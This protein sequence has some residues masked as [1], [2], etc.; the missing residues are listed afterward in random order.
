MKWL[1]ALIIV[2]LAL[3]TWLVLGRYLVERRHRGELVF[4]RL[5]FPRGLEAGTVESFLDGL[6]GLLS[7]WWRRWVTSPVVL[8]ETVATSDGISHQLGVSPGSQAVVEGLLQ[9][10]LPALRYEVVEPPKTIAFTS[11]AEYRTTSAARPLRVEAEDLSGKTLTSL[12]PLEADE[13]VVIQWLTTPHAPVGPVQIAPRNGHDCSRAFLSHGAQTVATAEAATA[14]KAKQAAPLLLANARIAAAAPDRRRA[15]QLVHQVETAW[16]GSR[17]P[18]VHLQRR[19]FPE[20]VAVRR[21][22]QRVA[23]MYVWPV[24]VNT[25]E[26]AGLIGWPVGVVQLPG[27]SLGAARLL[28]PSAAIPTTGT[29][30]GWSTYPGQRRPLALDVEARLRHVHLLGPTGTGKSTLLAK[31]ICSDVAAGH[32]VIVLDPKGDLVADVLERVPAK[33]R[34]D[35][36]VLDPTDVE[37]PVGLNPLAVASGTSAEVVVENLVGLFKSLYRDS[38]GPRTDDIFR[39]ALL[40]LAMSGQATLCEVPLLLTNPTYRRR[41]VGGL[42]DPVG[43]APFW[44]WF[45]S[46]KDGERFAVCGPVLNKIRAFVMRPTVRAIIGQADPKLSLTRVLA[47]GKVLLVSLASGLLGEEAA[48]LLGALVVAELWHATKARAGFPPGHRLPFMAYLDEWQNLLHLPTPMASVLAEARGLGLGLT[49]AHQSLTQLPNEARDAVL[50]NARSRVCF[51]LPSADARLIARDLGGLFTADDLMGLSAYEV[52]LAAFAAGSTQPPATAETLPMTPTL[53][54]GAVLRTA[55]RSQ[56]G[57]DRAEVDAAILARQE[58][59]RGPAP[60]RRKPV[61]G[62]GRAS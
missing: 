17:A 57:R 2:N 22:R 1:V 40:T 51:Q 14:L 10:S 5:A 54:G 39:A 21:A 27:L 35:V 9:A 18:G 56:F 26:L 12:Q 4:L 25:A 16:H 3:I 45:E 59:P 46:L 41:L 44:G 8:L 29:V 38:W 20:R 62:S 34:A 23:L 31:M 48:N 37:R 11:A 24:V 61:T 32:G 7:P 50:S 43:L 58:D 52:M 53:G 36:V 55:S 28:A 47:E 49:L 60:V 13:T 33:R 19:A 42:D 15:R 6:S 30:I